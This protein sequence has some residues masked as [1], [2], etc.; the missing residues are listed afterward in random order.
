MKRTE[1]CFAFIAAAVAALSGVLIAENEKEP[2][3]LKILTMPKSVAD[4]VSRDSRLV[5]FDPKTKQ[6]ENFVVN[7]EVSVATIPSPEAVLLEIESRDEESLAP[8]VWNAWKLSET[9]RSLAEHFDFRGYFKGSLRMSGVPEEIQ[10]MSFFM[11]SED[12]VSGWVVVHQAVINGEIED[13]V[14]SPGTWICLPSP[15]A[16]PQKTVSE[17]RL[18]HIVAAK[19]VCQYGQLPIAPQHFQTQLT[20]VLKSQPYGSRKDSEDDPFFSR[21]FSENDPFG[22]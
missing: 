4:Y 11:V 15:D 2:Q 9:T 10:F 20:Q 14:F 8:S 21:P 5:V 17:A 3:I 1:K 12:G 18:V 7:G 6:T 19:N 16:S 13:D 22:K